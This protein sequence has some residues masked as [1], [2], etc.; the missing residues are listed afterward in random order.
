MSTSKPAVCTPLLATL[1]SSLQLGLQELD[2]IVQL[3]DAH[4]SERAADI[5]SMLLDMARTISAMGMNAL[6][7]FAQFVVGS[8]GRGLDAAA[9]AP[10]RIASPSQ[11]PLHA[12]AERSLLMRKTKAMKAFSEV[13]DFLAIDAM[14][15]G[16]TLAEATRQLNSGGVSSTECGARLM[17]FKV[18]LGTICHR[19]DWAARNYWALHESVASLGEVGTT[20]GPRPDTPLR[21]G[22]SARV[23][24]VPAEPMDL[25]RLA[26]AAE[27]LEASLLRLVAAVIQSG[28]EP[29]Q[30]HRPS[31]RRVTATA[32]RRQW[33]H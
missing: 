12:K 6:H 8:L 22:D 28:D 14:A 17:E 5:P 13:I 29:A 4:D 27:F 11:P 33:L 18:R 2:L 10:P 31:A 9:Q 25:Q 19:I 7:A 1:T 15:L 21:I 16:E 32:Q 20:A 26:A 23:A 24:R 30:V 3:N